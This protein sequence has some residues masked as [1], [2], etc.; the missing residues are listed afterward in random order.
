MLC[1]ASLLAM[2][3]VAALAAVVGA[4]AQVQPPATYYGTAT[5]D[6]A[7][8]PDGTQVRAFVN[9]VDC[10]QDGSA[11]TFTEGGVSTFVILVMH[12]SQADGCATEGALVTFVIGDVAAAQ[13][14][15]WA[16]GVG[17]LNLS[18]GEGGPVALPTS[19]QTATPAP[20][21][22][23]AAPLLTPETEGEP[24]TDDPG[25]LR[26]TIG[27]A[28]II[29]DEGGSSFLLAWVVVILGVVA[30]GGAARGLALSR[31]RS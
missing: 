6:G 27:D 16:T 14:T 29:E 30:L 22:R 10:T 11:G 1:R 3:W 12:D 19:T 7:N 2:V 20:S 31:K 23:T 5:I 18:A 17:E 28:V 24:P 9:G 4:M 15:G 8:V 25:V 13:T 26:P 21:D